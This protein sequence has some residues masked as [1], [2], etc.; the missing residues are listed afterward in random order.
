M[1]C[2]SVSKCIRKILRVEVDLPNPDQPN[3]GHRNKEKH[4]SISRKIKEHTRHSLRVA[5][6]IGEVNC[7]SNTTTNGTK[8]EWVD[9]RVDEVLDTIPIISTSNLITLMIRVR[10]TYSIP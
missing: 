6:L 10:H 8:S 9:L 3:K 1:P 5:V 4:G 7:H 2:S